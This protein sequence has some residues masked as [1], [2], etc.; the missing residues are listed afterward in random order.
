MV[1]LLYCRDKLFQVGSTCHSSL[2]PLDTL[3][4]CRE[5]GLVKEKT[6]RG[7]RGGNKRNKSCTVQL[8]GN[9]D[10]KTSG[11]KLKTNHTNL[12]IG[13]H[14]V[15]SVNSKTH[16]LH[17]CVVDNS[18]DIFFM[19]ETWLKDVG[20]DVAITELTP[21]GYTFHHVPRSTGRGGGVG[22]L[23][24]SHL[25]LKMMKIDEKYTSFESLICCLTA[26]S[27]AFETCLPV[28]SSSF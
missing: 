10:L 12:K 4:R 25:H 15:Q 2:L 26:G 3:K 28:P 21:P 22:V 5:L 20:G 24:R 27:Q 9:N 14:N 18:F 17:E 8:T 16:A 11:T 19:T 7:V 1:Q 6:Q 23:Y 13:L